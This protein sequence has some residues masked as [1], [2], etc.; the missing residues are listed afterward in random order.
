MSEL[1]PGNGLAQ[2]L[3]TV[4]PPRAAAVRK[5]HLHRGD[6]FV[7][8]C[9]LGTVVNICSFMCLV[10]ISPSSG[11]LGKAQPLFPVPRAVPGT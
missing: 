4:S 1:V 7:A 3:P 2:D 5:C 10:S 8:F 11:Q 6:C 9:V